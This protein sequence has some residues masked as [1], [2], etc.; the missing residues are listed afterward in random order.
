MKISELA[1]QSGVPLAT[2]KFYLR[3]GLL[4]PGVARGPNQSDYDESHLR[5]LRLIRSLRELGGLSVSTIRQVVGAVGRQSRIELLGTAVD[6]LGSGRPEVRISEAERAGALAEIDELFTTLGWLVRPNAAARIQLA[7]T[8][9]ALRRDMPRITAGA[10]VSY[11]T[12][13]H[14]I[15]EAELGDFSDDDQADDEAALEA[16]VRG[17]LLFE[18]VLLALRRAAHEDISIRHYLG[19]VNP[20]KLR[21]RGPQ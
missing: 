18:P 6:A 5:R 11:A 13:A 1:R 8:L 19:N 12:F 4:Q 21:S 16:V 17:T 10:F 2:I 15:A 14:A 3:E 20:A 7:E 9:A